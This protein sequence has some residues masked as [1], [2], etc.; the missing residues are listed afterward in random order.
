[1]YGPGGSPR[2]E[3]LLRK[4]GFWPIFPIK[5]VQ[6]SKYPSHLIEKM[7]SK[8]IFF[9]TASILGQPLRDNQ[10][11]LIMDAVYQLLLVAH[12]KTILISI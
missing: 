4:S 1:M 8:S 7:D 11:H 6:Y 5:F 3:S 12:Q 10:A 9:A 2:I